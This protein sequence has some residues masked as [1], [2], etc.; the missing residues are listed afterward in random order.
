M[1]YEIGEYVLD[2]ACSQAAAWQRTGPSVPIAENV[3]PQQLREPGLVEVVT[4]SLSRHGVAPEALVL[5]VTEQGVLAEEAVALEVLSALRQLGVRIALDD[6][7]T[8]FSSL[9]H[10]ARLPVDAI[11]VDRQFVAGTQPAHRAIVRAVA[12]LGQTLSLEVVAEGVETEAHASL[13]LTAGCT[14][15]QGWLFG[16]PVA[17]GQ[18]QALAVPRPRAPATPR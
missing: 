7:G 14:R 5:E 15:G 8:G 18:E 10:L 16:R 17:A 3:S 11:K 13:A 9:S 1:L 4:R 2:L 12:T 6:F